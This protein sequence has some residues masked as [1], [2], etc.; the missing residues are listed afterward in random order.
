MDLK[1]RNDDVFYGTVPTIAFAYLGK[2]RNHLLDGRF[3]LVIS[4]IVSRLISWL[5]CP[6]EFND[7]YKVRLTLIVLMWRIG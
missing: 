1:G 5:T 6:A 2:L 4:Q 3:S 7:A